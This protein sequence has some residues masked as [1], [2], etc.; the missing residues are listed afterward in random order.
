MI[1]FP[2]CFNGDLQHCASQLHGNL[3]FIMADALFELVFL[4]MNKFPCCFSG[5][6]QHCAS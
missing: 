4:I 2:F 1:E 3:L 6:L 5:D